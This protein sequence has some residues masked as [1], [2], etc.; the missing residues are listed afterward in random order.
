MLPQEGAVSTIGFAD[1]DLGEQIVDIHA[2]ARR[3]RHDRD[4]AGERV[5]AAEPVDLA[6]IGRAHCGE[7]HAVARGVSLGRSSALK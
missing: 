4:L 6:R 7:Q 2:R 1:V 3:L 5:G